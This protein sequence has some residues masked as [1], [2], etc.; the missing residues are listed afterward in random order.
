MFKPC[1]ITYLFESTTLWGGNKV[2]LEQAEALSEAGHEVTILSKDS[3]PSWYPLRLPVV[4]VPEFD[5]STVPESDIVIGTYWPTV[6]AAVESKKGVVVHLCQGYEGDYVE[7]RSLKAAIDEVYS[8]EIPKLTVSPH[9]D[10]FIRERF[11]AETYY[12]GQMLNRHIFYPARDRK[13]ETNLPFT[14]LVTGPFEV[15]FKNVAFTLRGVSLAKE[16]LG[17]RIRLVRVSQFPVTSAEKEIIEPDIYHFHVPHYSMGEIYRASDLFVSM[18]KEAEGFGLPALEAMACGTPAI[19]SRIS[20]YSTFGKIPDYALFIGSS[21]SSELA[22]A[23]A[24]MFSNRPLRENLAKKGLEIAQNFTKEAVIRRLET[25]FEEILYKDK[26]KKTKKTWNDFH[27]HSA[28]SQKRYWWDSPV[29]LEHCQRLVTGDPKTNF[30]QFLKNEFVPQLLDNGLSICSGSGEFERGVLDY[31]I[32]RAVDTY[33]IAEERV[34]E[35]RR[36]AREKNYQ[37][38][39]CVDDVNKAVFKHNHYD[40]FFSWAALHHIENLEGVCENVRMALKDGGLVVVQEFIGPNQ[41]QWTD[42]QLDIMK[43]ILGIL[44]ESLRIRPQTGELITN[45]ERYSVA[46]MNAVDPSEAIRS[47]DIIPLLEQ[48]FTIKTIRYFGGPLYNP[49]LGEII[50]NFNAAD[51]KDAALIRMVLLMEE[52]LV[53]E[54]I[55]DNNYAVIV[56]EKK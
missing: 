49:L 47:G 17:S 7:L 6:K 29:I 13:E 22:G 50:G 43:K 20:S 18:S 25:A 56:A 14:I 21:D 52:L 10:D 11:G 46:Y 27:I 48:F 45:I 33:E 51:E 2:A 39:F 28:A 15:D 34:H 53:E 35:G 42:K 9:L 4:S 31:G 5:A 44:P 55:L 23:I 1:K 3:G 36:I 54:G 8:Y 26:I 41:F 40:I 32:C 16:K 12:V 30:Y 37:I 38:H 19:L 24:E